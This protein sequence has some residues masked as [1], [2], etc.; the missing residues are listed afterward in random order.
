MKDEAIIDL[1]YEKNEL[2]LLKLSDKYEKLLIHIATGILGSRSRDVEECVNDTYL[3]IWKNI[4]RYDM[5]KASLKTYLK[6]IIRNTSINKLRDLSRREEREFTEDVSDIAMYYIDQRQNVESQ[7]FS[8]ENMKQ[9]NKI[10]AHLSKKDQELVI[11]KYYYLQSSK[12]IA[13]A[14]GMT[15]TAIDSRL[16]RLRNRMKLEFEKEIN[17]WDGSQKGAKYG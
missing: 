9:L 2:G 8:K 16:S 15:V 17:A 13:N 3:K 10:I 1:I 12:D 7:V 14:T 4:E 11:R 5:E 6:V